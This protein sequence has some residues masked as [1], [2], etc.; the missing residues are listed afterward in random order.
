MKFKKV[1]GKFYVNGE[2]FTTFAEA[3][4]EIKKALKGEGEG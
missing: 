2:E 1:N 4:A 3:W